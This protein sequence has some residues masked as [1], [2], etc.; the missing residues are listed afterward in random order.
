MSLFNIID[1]SVLGDERGKLIAL[2]TVKNVPFE[3]KRVYYIYDTEYNVARGFHAHRQLRQLAICISG[4]CTVLMDDGMN[5]EEVILNEPNKGLV[6]DPM[7]W[8][9]MYNF[10]ENC[11]LMVLAN[12]LYD[13]ADY[14]RDYDEFKRLVNHDS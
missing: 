6:I 1:F 13:E 9:E 7:Q 4:S 14:I 10:S 11:V 12:D 5:K 2:E 3:I 8:H